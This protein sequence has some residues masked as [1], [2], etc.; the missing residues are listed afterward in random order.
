MSSEPQQLPSAPFP[1]LTSVA[2]L[3]QWRAQQ[4]QE[5]NTVGFVPT[6]GALH[7]GHISLVNES[8]SRTDSTIVSIFVNPAQFA[9]TEDLATYPRTLEADLERLKAAQ[10]HPSSGTTPRKRGTFVEVKGLQEVMEG[11][12]RPGFFRGVATVVLKLFNLVQPTRAFFGQKDIQQC[13][14]LRRMLLDLHVPHPLPSDLVIIPTHRDATS[15]LALSSRNAYLSVAERPW[16][17]VLIDALKAC[18][19]EW[20]RQRN[21]NPDGRV[22]VGSVLN[23]AKKHFA[24]VQERASTSADG[25]GVTISPIYVELNDPLEL[26]HLGY[27]YGVPRGHGAILSG[28]VMLGRT[29]LI[30]NLVLEFDLN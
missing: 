17:T 1:I 5:G 6:M 18:E 25:A 30:D 12:S 4:L 7:D 27:D 26:T 20:T 19:H 2:E 22:L 8:L 21:E 16:A 3:R 14:L 10:Y 29:R 24:Q 13:L 23:E 11:V 28:A 9:P 15:H